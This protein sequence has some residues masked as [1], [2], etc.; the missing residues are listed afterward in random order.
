MSV[1]K[2]LVIETGTVRQI[3][4]ANVL[5]VGAGIN[6]QGA[7]AQP[8]SSA[9]TGKIYFDSTS[10]TFKVSENGGSYQGLSVGGGVVVLTGNFVGA[11]NN[12]LVATARWYPPSTVTVKRAWASIGSVSSGLTEFNV[13]RNGSSILPSL[14]SISSGQWRSLNVVVSPG[15]AVTVTDYLTISLVTANGGSDAVVFVEYE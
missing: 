12:P 14:V 13:L 3:A 1:Q 8:L 10:N 6:A 5:A 11:L 9:G 15:A 7:A 4:D 2:S